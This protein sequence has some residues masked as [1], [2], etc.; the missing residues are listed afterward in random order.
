MTMTLT[1]VRSIVRSISDLDI[2]DLSNALLDSYVKEGFQQIVALERRYPFYQQSYSLNSEVGTRAYTISAIGDIREIISV[3]QTGTAGQRLSLIPYDEG[4]AIW[5]GN[6]DTAGEPNFYSFWDHQ[7]H[8]WPKP[9][10]IYAYTVRAYR[11]PVYTWLTNI[12]E[13]I[14]ADE[15][16]HVLLTY[17]VLSRIYQRQ[18]DPQMS[19]MYMQSFEQGVGLARKDIMKPSSARPLVL[20][21]GRRYPT[22]TRWLQT[23]GRTL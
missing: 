11:N 10:V 6:L 14:D 20:S 9:S 3:V 19:A 2:T 22:M 8:L 23:L 21:G 12:T 17:F 16:F 13:A 18:E 1:D 5:L 15:W 4:E 7:I